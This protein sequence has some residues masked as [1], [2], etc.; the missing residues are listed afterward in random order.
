MRRM[1]AVVAALCLAFPA[2]AAADNLGE[3]R[4]LVVR[5]THG[6]TPF[7][8]ADVRRVVFEET[9]RWI[10]DT[11]FGQAWLAGDVTPWLPAFAAPRACP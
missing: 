1:L 4:T 9:D 5:A 3:I 7:S 10:R 6:P 2:G 11:S 8:D